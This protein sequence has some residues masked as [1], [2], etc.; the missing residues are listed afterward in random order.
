MFFTLRDIGKD[1]SS[2]SRAAQLQSTHPL[3]RGGDRR[4]PP[5]FPARIVEGRRRVSYEVRGQKRFNDLFACNDGVH[6]CECE[7]E[8]DEKERTPMKQYAGT[9]GKTGEVSVLCEQLTCP[10]RKQLLYVPFA[11]RQGVRQRT[12]RAGEVDYRSVNPLW[13]GDSRVPAMNWLGR[14]AIEHYHQQ[15]FLLF[16]LGSKDRRSMRR[17][18]GDAAHGFWN[19]LGDLLW[20]LTIIENI[21]RGARPTEL[22]PE[23]TCEHMLKNG[24]NVAR[25]R[26]IKK[27]AAAARA[28]KAR[29]TRSRRSRH[30]PAEDA[31]AAKPAKQAA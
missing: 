11:S 7:A 15:R 2:R 26:T 9:F 3:E 21:E 13:R 27:A 19:L 23:L 14:Q 29:Q 6:F 16:G 5:E 18:I 1:R 8:T 25:L 17:Y 31:E 22:D 12:A 20:N 28:K 4:E 24:R 30:K 10:H